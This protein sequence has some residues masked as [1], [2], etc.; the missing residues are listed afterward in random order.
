MKFSPLIN[1]LIDSLRCLPGVGA[2]SAQRMAF[3]LLQKNRTGALKLSAALH[4]AMEHVQH[5]ETCRN[6]TEQR[7][8]EICSDEERTA[9]GLLCVVESPQDVIA[10]EQSG[11]FSGLYFVLMGKLSPLDGIGPSEIGMPLLQ[12]RLTEGAVNEVILAT[13]FTMEGEATAYYITEMCKG[14]DI[15]VTRLA[16]GVPI[17]GELEQVDSNTLGRAFKTRSSL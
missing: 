5:C 1:E 6:F 13:N 4:D 17:G 10:I 8:C 12:Q 15:P 16:Q 14:L 3:S 7:L 2:K 11:E 9:S